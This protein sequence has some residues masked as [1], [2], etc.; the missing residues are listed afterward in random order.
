MKAFAS[1]ANPPLAANDMDANDS[2]DN[3]DAN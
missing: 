1:F 3:D 2:E